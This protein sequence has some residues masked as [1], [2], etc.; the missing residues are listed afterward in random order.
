[1]LDS[2][3]LSR[4]VGHSVHD[5]AGKRI[6]D[7]IQ[8]Y[9][10]NNEPRW[11]AVKRGTMTVRTDLVPAAAATVAKHGLT[12]SCHEQTV[13]WAPHVK[14]RHHMTDDEERSLLD[15]YRERAAS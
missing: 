10:A 12:V 6:G 1:M 4:W 14:D 7:L 3:T 13:H 2:D 15:Y 11:L 8:V 5:A 9:V